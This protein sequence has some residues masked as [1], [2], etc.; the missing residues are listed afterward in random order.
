MSPGPDG[1]LLCVH[2]CWCSLC[3]ALLDRVYYSQIRVCLSVC[4]LFPG[5]GV[6]NHTPPET[7]LARRV[8][9]PLGPR[10][11]PLIRRVHDV[12]SCPA[13][14]RGVFE[15]CREEREGLSHSWP[16]VRP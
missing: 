6:G 9:A 3:S 16:G 12:T 8:R 13:G 10:L 11:R 1:R 7:Q 4:G 14:G 2:Q 5:G 15:V